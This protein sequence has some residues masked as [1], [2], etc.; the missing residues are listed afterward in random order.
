[1]ITKIESKAIV[2]ETDSKKPTRNIGEKFK[3]AKKGII[4]DKNA[5]CFSLIAKR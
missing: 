3:T 4:G 2:N 1:M 5:S